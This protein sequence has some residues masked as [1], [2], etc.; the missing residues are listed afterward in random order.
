[1]PAKGERTCSYLV[2]LPTAA[3]LLCLRI[4]LSISLPS[5]GVI[6]ES[7][8]FGSL[9]SSQVLSSTDA[10]EGLKAFQKKRA[11]VWTER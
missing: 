2:I 5:S 10:I 7:Y 6:D 3:A 4:R 11:P 8:K 1:M 9:V